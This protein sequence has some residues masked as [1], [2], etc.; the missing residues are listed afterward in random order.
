METAAC[1]FLREHGKYGP[2]IVAIGS[3]WYPCPESSE[4]SLYIEREVI[5]FMKMSKLALT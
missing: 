5:S 4:T 2:Q 1:R 3:K